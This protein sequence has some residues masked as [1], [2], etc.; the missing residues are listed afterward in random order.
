[1][2]RR[3]LIAATL[4]AGEGHRLRVELEAEGR[5][6]LFANLNLPARGDVEVPAVGMEKA[7]RIPVRVLDGDGAPVQGV[8]VRP[9]SPWRARFRPAPGRGTTNR[10]GLSPPLLLPLGRV[11]LEIEGL[12]P[13][14]GR[15][16]TRT[17]VRVT[18]GDE[19]VARLERADP[20]HCVP[21]WS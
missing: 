5:M 20:A 3:Y 15:E 1:M 19:A 17:H 6:T 11:D 2:R 21:T 7:L 18:P 14:F 4:P 13:E 12:P 8:V 16:N 10:E 9:R